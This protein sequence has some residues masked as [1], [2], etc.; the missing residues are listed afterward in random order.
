MANNPIEIEIKF[1]IADLTGLEEKIKAVG[2][3]ELHHNVFQR[4]VRMDTPEE[5]LRERGVFLRVRDGE[6]RV[7]TVKSKLAG[8]DERFKERQELE[9]EISDVSMAEEMLVTLGYAKKWIMEKYRTEY[10][11]AGTVLALD[12]LPFGDY[13]EIEGDKESIEEAITILGLEDQEKITCSYWHLFDDYKKANGLV[14]EN[15]VF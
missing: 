9:I 5:S 8:S 11:L 7:M 4:T 2:G 15:I 10:E 13:L 12:H 1:K 6:K 3:K 14:G